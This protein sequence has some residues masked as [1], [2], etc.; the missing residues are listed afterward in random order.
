[1]V[2]HGFKGTLKGPGLTSGFCR[3]PPKHW[4]WQPWF[5]RA[6]LDFPSIQ[7]GGDGVGH[8]NSDDDD[9]DDDDDMHMNMNM[10]HNPQF[11]S[12]DGGA[13]AALPDGHR[14]TSVSRNGGA[15]GAVSSVSCHPGLQ[16]LVQAKT[17]SEFPSAPYYMYIYIYVYIYICICLLYVY[18]YLYIYMYIIC[19]YYIYVSVY[20]HITHKYQSI[21]MM[22]IRNYTQH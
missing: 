15:S 9:D 19:V 17:I 5:R 13:V 16:T 1:M 8:G 14:G 11:I 20:I 18:I 2:S 21:N 12:W 22:Y 4:T 7:K 6:R 10:N 3:H